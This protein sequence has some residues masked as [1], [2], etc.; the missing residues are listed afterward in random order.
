MKVYTIDELNK[1]RGPDKQKRKKRE[2]VYPSGKWGKEIPKAKTK[3]VWEK[4]G[5]QGYPS[6]KEVPINKSDLEL[7]P[8]D[9]KN[10]ELIRA[11]VDKNPDLQ[12]KLEGPIK[13][14]GQEGFDTCV[15]HL[16]GKKG[17]TN[18]KLLCGYLKGQARE[19]GV[20]KKEHM[21]LQEKKKYQAKKGKK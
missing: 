16:S 12:K 21:G 20:L 4:F 18:A 17:I 15:A 6:L 1:G 8:Q 7:T 10:I 3:F 2:K 11:M 9:E 14:V 13:W 5:T 19:R